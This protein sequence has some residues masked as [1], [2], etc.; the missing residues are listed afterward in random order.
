MLLP[1]NININI[2]YG[3]AV[4]FHQSSS[5]LNYRIVRKDFGGVH[6]VACR[7]SNH[8]GH[9]VS[10]STLAVEGTLVP[11]LGCFRSH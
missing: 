1:D 5:T 11:L 8:A 10:T 9:N 6:M 3:T 2:T 7:A 4:D